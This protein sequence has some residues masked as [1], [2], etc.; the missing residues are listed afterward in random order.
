MYKNTVL[1][2]LISTQKWVCPINLQPIDQAYYTPSRDYISMPLKEQFNNG[3]AFYSTLLHEM[4]HSTGIESRLN[5]N[6]FNSRDMKDYAREELVAELTSSLCALFFGIASTIRE[7]NAQYLKIWINNMK[8]E[9]KFIISVLS[10]SMKAVK[11]IAEKLN[12]NIC[13]MEEETNIETDIL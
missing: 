11:Y 9:P 3:Q 4:A 13:Q 1:D 2:V 8:E 12:I 6:G 7:E 10:D 5:R